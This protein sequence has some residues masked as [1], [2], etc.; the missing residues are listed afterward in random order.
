MSVPK[1]S[2]S[3]APVLESGAPLI[4]ERTGRQPA[5]KL[6]VAWIEDPSAGSG[7]HG[8]SGQPQGNHLIGHD[9]RRLPLARCN[10]GIEMGKARVEQGLPDIDSKAASSLET[11]T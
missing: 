6:E 9:R 1:L 5:P 11:R 8:G 7:R 2:L 4:I 3:L 10:A